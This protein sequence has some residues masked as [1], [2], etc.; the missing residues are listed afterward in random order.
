MRRLPSSHASSRCSARVAVLPTTAGSPVL[1]NS[2]RAR[3]GLCA[4]KSAASPAVGPACPCVARV[5]TVF[6]RSQRLRTPCPVRGATPPVVGGLESPCSPP[7]RGVRDFALHARFGVR[8]LLPSPDKVTVLLALCRLRELGASVVVRDRL[9]RK[10]RERCLD[11]FCWSATTLSSVRRLR[12]PGKHAPGFPDSKD[13]TK[14]PPLFDVSRWDLKGYEVRNHL[15][16]LRLPF[17]EVEGN[18]RSSARVRVHLRSILAS[19]EFHSDGGLEY[20]CE[21]WGGSPAP[22][23]LEK[24]TRLGYI[25]RSY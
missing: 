9:F 14:N 21:E 5:R 2:Y 16:L 19:A 24:E 17:G 15:T 18:L 1:R 13:S 6:L 12:P 4:S 11:F 8:R 23:P 7:Q 25:R 22:I 3:S 10:L 20:C